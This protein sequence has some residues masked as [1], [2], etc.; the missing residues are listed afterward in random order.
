MEERGVPG[1]RL[2]GTRGSRG[3]RTDE[4]GASAQS[5][6][7]Y[8][9]MIYYYG[10]RVSA[11]A[12]GFIST[13]AGEGS[14]GP[15]WEREPPPIKTVGGAGDKPGGAPRGAW[16]GGREYREAVSSSHLCL[17]SSV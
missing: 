12:V 14:R 3:L 4:T 1:D 2:R 5:F 17:F 7:D 10:G 8:Y 11:L 16:L 13:T 15:G 9:L 6:C